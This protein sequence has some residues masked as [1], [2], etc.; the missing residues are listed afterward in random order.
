MKRAVVFG[1]GSFGQLVDL[2]LRTDG[3]YEIPAFAVTDD[4]AQ[5]MAAIFS[6]RP[7][8][9]LGQLRELFD[10]GDTEVFV[11][12]G[13]RGMNS[14][15]RDLC[16]AVKSAGFRLLSYV[17]S[18][19]VRWKDT[20]IGE[21]VFIFEDNTIQPFTSIGDGVVMWSGNHLGHHSV[22]EDWTFIASHA[23]VSGHCRIGEASFLGVN[24]TIADG[25]TIGP[26]NLIGPG[27]LIQKNTGADEAWFAERAS[28]FVRPSSY[29]FK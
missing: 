27:A 26:R 1:T 17:H 21:N 23:V 29:F 9:G 14:V 7:V 24:S 13:Y 3:G 10:P 6:G 8:V 28:K 18:N 16:H 19:V 12:V 15:R 5:E 2:Y 22:V 20:A 4:H 11:A 25:I